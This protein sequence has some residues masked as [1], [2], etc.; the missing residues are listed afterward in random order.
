M[1]V[2]V[3]DAYSDSGRRSLLSAG[4]TVMRMEGY[5]PGKVHKC[6]TCSENTEVVTNRCTGQTIDRTGRYATDDCGEETNLDE[7]TVFPLC[8]KHN[9]DVLWKLLD[10]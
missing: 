6:P 5:P 10:G 1:R 9:T 8:P 3:L 2:L 7:G 4:G